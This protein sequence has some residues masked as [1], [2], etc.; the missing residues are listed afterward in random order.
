[1]KYRQPAEDTLWPLLDII[2]LY[3]ALLLTTLLISINAL[4]SLHML[5]TVVLKAN[6]HA[7]LRHIDP[8][9]KA[10][11]LS[12]FPSRDSMTPRM[13]TSKLTK[14]TCNRKRGT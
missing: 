13:P 14:N 1:M 11:I 9:S 8:V 2:H 7:R 6:I 4:H 10:R 12:S 5:L 3:V